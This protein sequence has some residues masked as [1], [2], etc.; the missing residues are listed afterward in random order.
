MAKV[1]IPD[2]WRKKQNGEK[3]ICMVC[4]DYTTARILDRAGADILLIGDTGG[5]YL[6]GNPSFEATTLDE[7]LLMTRSV[8]R[9]AQ[10]AFVVGDMPF[11]SYQVN[12][13][14]A[15][16]NAGRYIKESGGDA[17]KLEGGKDFAPTVQAIVKAGVPVMAHMGFTPL[18]T[19]GQG[20][21]SGDGTTVP[22]AVETDLLEDAKALEAAG[23]FS[24]VLTRIPIAV[25]N[26]I[27]EE[28]SVPTLGLSGANTAG[29]VGV[30]YGTFGM[31]LE[32]IEN[33]RARYGPLAK[34]LYDTACAYVQDVRPGTPTR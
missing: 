7:M 27:S 5:R 17:I 23:A 19:L 6:L 28:V 9:G 31:E 3:I 10:R 30:I 13:E 20:V 1:S 34:V 15:V 8:A 4:Y 25:A 16:R 14:E 21:W 11:M 12:V 26:R 32:E 22:E 24:I 18:T 2:V 29:P 33:P